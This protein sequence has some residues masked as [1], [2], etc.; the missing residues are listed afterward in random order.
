[1]SDDETVP[2]SFELSTAIDIKFDAS[3]IATNLNPLETVDLMSGPWLR[4]LNWPASLSN[5]SRRG[6]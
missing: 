1:M 6:S 2:T 5:S 4:R 3:D